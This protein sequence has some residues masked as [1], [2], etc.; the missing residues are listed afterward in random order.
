MDKETNNHHHHHQE[1]PSLLPNTTTAVAASATAIT[2]I[3]KEESPRKPLSGGGGGGDRLKRDEWSEGAVSS[4]LEAYER[5]WVLRNRAK[6]KGLD[7]EDVARYVSSRANSTKS[8]KTQTQCKNKIESMKK[9]YRSESTAD[10]S[11]WP[12]YSRLD[13]LLRGNGVP[14]TAA[15]S[16]AVVV[17]TS[18]PAQPP[19]PPMPPSHPPPHLHTNNSPLLLLEPTPVAVAMVPLPP[20]PPSPPPPPLHAAPPLIGAAQ[21]SHGSNGVERLTKD[22]TGG[23]NKMLISD[24]ASD[25][26]INNNSMDITSDSSTPALYSEK[27]EKIRSS[28]RKAGTA[29][30]KIMKR[31]RKK[32]R[33]EELEVA[34]SIRWLAEAVLKSE[35]ARMEAMRE[36]ERMRV[37]AEAKRAEME[38][39]RTQIIANTQ[40]EIAKLF[41]SAVHVGKA[42]D[43]SLRIGRN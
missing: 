3:P 38:L 14:P 22:D 29:V 25:K 34:E 5:K 15:A 35:Q 43:S 8:P 36:I 21:N 24:H 18:S 23:I 10:A 37:E 6:L 28:S 16:A 32:K 40:L 30:N 42:V 39:K 13:L 7:W 19:L 20:P 2:V 4:L 1:S 12:L 27:A 33:K 11:S 41:A 9:R 17:T 31:K 26:K